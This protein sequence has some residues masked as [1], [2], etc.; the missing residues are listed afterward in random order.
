ML[1]LHKLYSVK[2]RGL[3]LRI[4]IS[5]ESQFGIFFH[6]CLSL[7]S[8]QWMNTRGKGIGILYRVKYRKQKHILQFEILLVVAMTKNLQFSILM[9]TIRNRLLLYTK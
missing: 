5:K 8:A 2:R 3:N 6:L 9:F 4:N 7:S 1:I